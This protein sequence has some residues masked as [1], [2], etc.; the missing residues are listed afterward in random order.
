MKR[1]HVFIVSAIAACLCVF[2]CLAVVG[3]GGSNAA[4]DDASSATVEDAERQSQPTPEVPAVVGSWELTEFSMD[5]MTL[6]IDPSSPDALMYMNLVFDED[7]TG[8]IAS[9]VDGEGESAVFEY[10]IQGNAVELY[11]EG[12]ALSEAGL[13]TTVDG[14]ELVMGGDFEG[15]EVAITFTRVDAATLE[16]HMAALGL[17]AASSTAV[18]DT[19]STGSSSS[20]TTN[21]L[22]TLMGTG[23]QVGDVTGSWSLDTVEI[24]GYSVT[25]KEY[26]EV[27]GDTT[28]DMTIAFDPDGTGMISSTNEG[29]HEEVPFTYEFDGQEILI[30]D[31]GATSP[32]TSIKITYDP[33]QEVI[34]I[35]EPSTDLRMTLYRTTI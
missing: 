32:D 10:E 33:D 26:R 35:S 7:G 11:S 9:Y 25:V 1:L 13:A 3:C 15:S 29:V 17:T 30:T 21:N 34:V 18:P 27:T 5:G 2:C 12:Y 6:A 31:E 24:G 8:T 16:T 28:F 23:Q 22:S 4:S 20:D 19:S 14:D